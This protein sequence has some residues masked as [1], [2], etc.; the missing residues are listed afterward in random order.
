MTSDNQNGKARLVQSYEIQK[1]NKCG[2]CWRTASLAYT[3]GCQPSPHA[4]L[5]K[6][7]PGSQAACATAL[8]SRLR[9]IDQPEH[10]WCKQQLLSIDPSQ[11]TLSYCNIDGNI[12]FNSYIATM[13]VLPKEDGCNIEW[14]YEVEPIEGWTLKD[15]DMLTG[16]DLQEMASR[17]EASLNQ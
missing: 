4:F 5:C 2:L 14:K 16:T 12:G 3:S 8:E 6:A 1:Q 9:L 7:Y 17:M 11:M 15:L 13:R 10:W